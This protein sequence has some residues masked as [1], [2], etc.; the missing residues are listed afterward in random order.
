MSTHVTEQDLRHFAS[1]GFPASV[2]ASSATDAGNLVESVLHVLETPSARLATAAAMALW[3]LGTTDDLDRLQ[4][5]ELSDAVRRRLGY[6]AERLSQ[7]TD[8]PTPVTRSLAQF[9]DELHHASDATKDPLTL[10]AVTNPTLVD[11]FVSR[12][13]ELDKKWCV[14]GKFDLPAYA[15][16]T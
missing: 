12:S 7:N 4:E 2:S 5:R 14:F 9:A 11:L 13:D 16:L 15:A 3:A 10:M 1:L 6:L 8:T